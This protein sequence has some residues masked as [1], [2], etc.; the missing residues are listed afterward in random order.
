MH[1]CCM[2]KAALNFVPQEKV[3]PVWRD[4]RMG[5]WWQA[6]ILKQIICQRC[7]STGHVNAWFL[8]QHFRLELFFLKIQIIFM[9][10]FW[11]VWWEKNSSEIISCTV[12]MCVYPYTQAYSKTCRATGSNG[13]TKHETC[14]L[15]Q[16]SF[17][18]ANNFAVNT[19]YRNRK[20]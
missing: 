17:T 1:I 5:R 8:P 15:K 20:K 18:M 11:P 6:F 9:W 16:N 12:S 2:K 14:K 10:K 13:E 19:C 3:I 4:I 7:D